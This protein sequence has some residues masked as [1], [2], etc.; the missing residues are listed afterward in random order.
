[1]SETREAFAQ[2]AESLVGTRFRLFGRDPAYG[3][4]CV[5]LVAA[6]LARSGR[7]VSAPIGYGLRSAD[8][9]K[10]LPFATHA[11]LEPCSGDPMRGDVLL[12]RPGPAQH[13]LVIATAPHMIV[14]AH[15]G[16]RRIVSQP[17]PTDPEPAMP[18]LRAWRLPTE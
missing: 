16:L 2:A 3:L 5:G 17:L 11:G 7:S 18:I 12:M 9:E 6:A 15:A 10:F 1:M 14:H 4:D 8:I 13:H